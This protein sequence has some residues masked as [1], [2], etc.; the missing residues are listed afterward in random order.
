[1]PAAAFPADAHYVALGHLHRR[2][3]AAGALPGA[4]TAGAPLAVDFG[5]QDNTPVVCLVEA[6][7]DHAGRVTD[8]PITAGRR[9][10]R[11]AA[12]VA[13]LVGAR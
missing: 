1:M 13:E 5:E 12:R 10:R 4:T 3:T 2:Q 7:P 9:L 11:C 6:A 8:V